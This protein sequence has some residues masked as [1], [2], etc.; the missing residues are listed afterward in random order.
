MGV[1]DILT[2]SSEQESR[3]KISFGDTCRCLGQFLIIIIADKASNAHSQLTSEPS[4]GALPR[5]GNFHG[6][7]DICSSSDSAPYTLAAAR[8]ACSRNGATATGSPS[9][10]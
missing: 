7:T 3:A 8:A 4:S 9:L 6:L 1:G 2:G 5:I 10:E